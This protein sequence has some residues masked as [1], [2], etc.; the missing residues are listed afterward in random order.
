[1]K[2]KLAIISIL[3]FLIIIS[4]GNDSG[5][6]TTETGLKFQDEV[7]GEGRIAQDGDLVSVQFIG[8]I[9]QDSTNLF[10]DWSADSTKTPYL[11]GN[12]YIHNQPI[13]FVLGETAFIKG[14]DEGIS[15]M[16]VGGK[17]TLIIPSEIAYGEQGAGPVPPNTDLKVDIEL[18][19]VTDRVMVEMW[20]LGTAKPKS[21]A[22]G[23]KYIV[24]EE[25]EGKNAESG[26]VV[27]V[28]YSG[29]LEDG[30]KF[31]SSVEKN[32]PITFALGSKQVIPGWD[33]GITYMKKGS[34]VRLIV[35]PSLGYGDMAVGKIPAKS[36][37]I[38]DVELIDIK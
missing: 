8:W 16:K 13:K 24:V 38:F 10:S 34:K 32:E 35:P 22:S 36:T 29:F 23:L 6:T 12:S 26:N 5:V 21:T 11:I 9:I 17:R 18:V 2:T 19:D 20:E 37:L 14:T 3:T 30:T 15:G 1:M 31:D 28:H 25:G 33:E 27:T 4:C 7:V